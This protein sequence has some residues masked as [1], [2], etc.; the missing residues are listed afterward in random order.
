[1]LDECRG[2]H[3]LL[4]QGPMGPFFARL[5]EDLVAHGAKVSR[6]VL[7]AGDAWFDKGDHVHA[8][9]EPFDAWG[10]WL[11]RFIDRRG[12]E[13]I[14]LFGDMRPHHRVART[15]A[16]RVGIPVYVFEEGYLRPDHIT[17]ELGG[18]NGNSSMPKDPQVYRDEALRPFDDVRSVG[19]TFWYAAVYSTVYA[20]AL[21]HLWRRFPHYRHHRPLNAWWQLFAWTR[22]GL[23]KLWFGWR[24]RHALRRFTGPLSGR[25]FIVPLQ[26]HCDAQLMHSD[27]DDVADFMEYV[28]QSFADH[29]PTDRHLVFKHH[30][31]DRPFREYGAFVRDLARRHGLTGRL[32]YVHDVHL[33][34]LLRHTLGTVTINSTTGL[35]AVHHG[36]PVKVLGS[37]VYDMPGLTSQRPLETFWT[38][39]DDVDLELY[40]AF[41]GWLEHHNQANGSVW[42]RLPGAASGTGL[43]WWDRA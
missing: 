36:A 5:C 32:H 23:R 17:C 8:F 39:P 11:E 10:T 2:K 35:S 13:A 9:T 42:K 37:A 24:E 43:R 19:S 27:F 34:S 18:V 22:G 28:A 1:M 20:L 31:A 33:P 26:V 16:Q 40:V 29:A 25:F 4:L 30:P 12:V 15:V 21:T 38:N 6:V 3:V 7:N 41:R 14:A